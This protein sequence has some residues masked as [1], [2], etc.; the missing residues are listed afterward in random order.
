MQ[1]SNFVPFFAAPCTVLVAHSKLAPTHGAIL[2]HLLVLLDRHFQ[3][4][5]EL[6]WVYLGSCRHWEHGRSKLGF[7]LG[8]RLWLVLVYC[9]ANRHVSLGGPWVKE[10]LTHIALDCVVNICPINA[11]YKI[12]TGLVCFLAIA[13]LA[14]FGQSLLNSLL[15]ILL[16]SYQLFLGIFSRL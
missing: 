6:D 2:L 14:L 15:Q 9:F 11:A 13:L 7:V 5:A 10:P 3:L 16:S 12:R 1:Y 4:G 8:N